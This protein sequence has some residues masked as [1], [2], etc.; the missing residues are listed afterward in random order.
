KYS[1]FPEKNLNLF[2]Y[3]N[4]QYLQTIADISRIYGYA[5]LVYIL[6]SCPTNTTL[7]TMLAFRKMSIVLHLGILVVVWNQLLFIFV[8]HIFAAVLSEKI[9]KPAKPLISFFVHSSRN[10]NFRTK[11]KLHFYIEQFHSKKLYG[12]TYGNI[13][14]VSFQSFGKVSTAKI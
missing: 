9:H 2:L 5:F 7:I 11:I 1:N 6:V 12:L 13:S 10:L 4:N 8:V 14:V 3:H